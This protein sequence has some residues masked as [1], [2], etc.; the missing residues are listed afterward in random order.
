MPRG[1]SLGSAV[2]AASAGLLFG[3]ALLTAGAARAETATATYEIYFGGFQV[4]TATAEWE[5]GPGGYHISGEA[6]TQ[7]MVGWLHPWKGA[8]ESR[9]QLTAGHVIPR[10]YETRGTS[11]EGDK[12]VRL[13]YDRQGHL[14]DSLVQP[15]QDDEER[16]LLPANA[17]DGTLDPLSVVAGLAELLRNGGRCEGS[18]PVFDGR[19]RY[20][21]FVSDAGEK[22]LEPTSY[23]IFAGKA[24][25]C[26]L[27]YKLLGGHRVERNKYAETARERIVWV[28]RPQQGA[29][30]IP[31]RL[32]IETAYGS[33]MGHIT[34]FEEDTQVAR[35]SATKDAAQTRPQ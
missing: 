22:V 18:F 14:V 21:V 35:R 7:G 17:G 10:L 4:L 27:D 9:G 3:A 25:G 16:Y 31:V 5:R 20:D 8:T 1:F 2:A 33:V 19:K 12:L 26:R 34:G 23:S 15:Q 28:A 6:E 13:S 11:D 30:L 24:H 32:E 29:P